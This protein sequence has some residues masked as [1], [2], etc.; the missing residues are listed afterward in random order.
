M[1]ALRI[2]RIYAPRGPDDGYRVLADRLWPRGIGKEAAGLDGWA[3][4]VAPSTGLRKSFSHRPELFSGFRSAYRAELDANPEAA[5]LARTCRAELLS[6]N[7]TVLY[8][9][10]D[11]IC[12]NASVLCEWMRE[13]WEKEP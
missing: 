7:V 6:R 2:K 10:R 3:R 9:A 13:Q 11:E 4:D 5:A 1:Y 8:A 12:N